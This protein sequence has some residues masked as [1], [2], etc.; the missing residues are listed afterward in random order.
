[1]SLVIFFY[2]SP[3]VAAGG[4]YGGIVGENSVCCDGVEIDVVTCG[5]TVA[6]LSAC[7]HA[8]LRA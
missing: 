8:S 6:F 2:F 5:C 4:C 1:M 7:S 3:C